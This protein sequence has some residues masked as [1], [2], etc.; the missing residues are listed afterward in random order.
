VPFGPCFFAAAKRYDRLD[1]R[2]RR[3][4]D[5]V[6]LRVTLT[7]CAILVVALVAAERGR[8]DLRLSPTRVLAHHLPVLEVR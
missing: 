2:C 3:G 8:S 4:W 6:L 5:T 1:T 7:F